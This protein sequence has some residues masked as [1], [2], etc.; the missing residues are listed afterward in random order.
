MGSKRAM[1]SEEGRL[2][3]PEGYEPLY[4]ES[5][6]VNLIG[7]IYQKS[8]DDCLRLGLRAGDKHCNMRGDIHGG[9]VSSLADIA[10]GYNIAFSQQPSI[11]AVTATLTVDYVGRISRGDWLEVHTDI[12]KLGKRLAFANCFFFVGDQRVARANAVFNVLNKKVDQ[13]F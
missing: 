11:S 4:R 1:K 10:L 13:S 7:P 5:A 6:F 2:D 8:T 12:Q 9:V 3:V